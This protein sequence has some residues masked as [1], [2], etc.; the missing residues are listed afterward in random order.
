MRLVMVLAVA[1]GVALASPPSWV[2][3]GQL[4]WELPGGTFSFATKMEVLWAMPLWAWKGSLEIK[5]GFWTGLSFSGSGKVGLLEIFPTVSFDPGIPKFSGATL[6]WKHPFAQGSLSGVARLEEKG[7]GFGLTYVGGRGEALQH[8]R[9]RFNL[10]RY[11][12]EVLENT[13]A[14]EFSFLDALFRIPLDFCR[15]TLSAR[16]SYTKAGFEALSLGLSLPRGLPCDLGFW[17]NILFRVDRKDARIFPSLVYTPPPGIILFL[18]VDWDGSTFRGI[19]IYA[20]GLQGE[21]GPLRYRFFTSLAEDEISFI[22]DP[23]WE[24]LTLVFA[25]P[26][27]CG[28]RG[29]VQ[30]DLYFGNTGLFGLGEVGILGKLPLAQNLQVS[31]G[32]SAS[33]SGTQKLSLGWEMSL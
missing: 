32:M 4:S 25:F 26:G 30:V 19:K 23:Y 5:D 11:L 14:P 29:E 15:T 8:L 27:C 1:G 31:F 10:K 7:F 3:Q 20:F 13:F 18:G 16:F 12:D 22:K 17:A 21:V 9:L 28:G 24:T 2:W 6:G 33:H